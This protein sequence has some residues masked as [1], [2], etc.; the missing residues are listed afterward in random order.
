[1]IPYTVGENL[2]PY[3]FVL[4]EKRIYAET[5]VT[6]LRSSHLGSTG[7]VDHVDFVAPSYPISTLITLLVQREELNTIGSGQVR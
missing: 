3:L 1:M 7:F 2:A 4:F 5:A 6:V